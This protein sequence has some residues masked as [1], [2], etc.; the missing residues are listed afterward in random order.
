MPNL[1]ALQHQHASKLSQ[2]LLFQTR[3]AFKP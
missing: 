2:L 1:K 3:S